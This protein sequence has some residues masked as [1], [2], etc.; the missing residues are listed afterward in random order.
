M[1]KYFVSS[2][3]VLLSAAL[4]ECSILSNMMILPVIPDLSLL[5]ILFFSIHNGKFF[6]EINGLTSGIF[7]DFLSSAPFGLNCLLRS[8]MSYI[9]GFF[10][11]RIN[12]EGIFIPMILGALATIFKMIL[13]YIFSLIF[14][15]IVLSYNPFSLLFLFE[16]ILNTILTPFVFKL[17][18]LLSRYLIL[19]PERIR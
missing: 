16:L 5:C 1:I 18:K 9:F 19:P 15:D 17:L 10:N 2:T 14:K 8:T 3:L 4:I 6:G 13:I 12:S 11:K 7:I